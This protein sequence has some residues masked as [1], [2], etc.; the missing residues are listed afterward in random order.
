MKKQFGS[1]VIDPERHQFSRDGEQ[2]HIEP[3][4]FDL[5]MLLVDHDGATVSKDELI[6]IVWRGLNVSEATISARINAARTAVGDNGRSQL[7]I[8]T[9]PRR[10]FRLVVPVHDPDQISPSAQSPEPDPQTIRFTMSADGIQ[11]A[12]AQ[13]GD[14][15]PLLRAGHWLSHLEMDWN[16]PIWRPMLHNLGR[17]RRLIR[18][19]Q[20]GTALSG[21]EF[22]GV[23]LDEFVDDLAAVADACGLDDFPILAPSQAAPV[24]I[25]YAVRHPER[26]SKLILLGGFAVGRARRPPVP[27]DVDEKIM[28]SLIQSGWGQQNDAFIQAFS[29]FFIPD[30]SK[31]EIR[32]FVDIQRGSATAEVAVR[33]RHLIDRFDVSHLMSQVQAPTLVIH[34]NRDVVHPIEQGRLLAS[35][36][37]D[38][39]FVMLDS[40]NHIHLPGHPTFDHMMSEIEIFLQNG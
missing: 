27:G 17:N 30:A 36:I 1:C 40:A 22:A 39:R 9:V 23:G 4:V 33:L 18:Y 7:V 34:A 26:V 21:R 37:P 29:S 2:I 20:R 16:S 24:A 8:K 35:G 28:L 32:S 15:P 11:I 6:R 14:G 3:Q 5:L 13:S 12:Y 31:E 19:D 38:A 25:A 10:G